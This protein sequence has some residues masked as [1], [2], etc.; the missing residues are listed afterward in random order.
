MITWNLRCHYCLC[1]LFPDLHILCHSWHNHWEDAAL[2]ETR[3]ISPRFLLK[4]PS[5]RH[6]IW[7]FPSLCVKAP[8]PKGKVK[9]GKKKFTWNCNLTKDPLSPISGT[10]KLG[11]KMHFDISSFL[12]FFSFFLKEHV[13]WVLN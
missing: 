13:L 6:T 11:E 10:Q 2:I 7:P 1:L 12:Y 9:G 5:A 4:H 3:P 8:F